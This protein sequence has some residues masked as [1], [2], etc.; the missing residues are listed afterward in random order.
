M[1]N[2]INLWCAFVLELIS[3]SFMC[4]CVC[5]FLKKKKKK[6]PT[7]LFSHLKIILLQCFQF[8]IFS[9]SKNKFNLKRPI[10]N[11]MIGLYLYGFHVVHCG[12]LEQV[13]IVIMFSFGF[14]YIKS[15]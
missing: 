6:G 8:S 1:G 4:V 14:V 11:L 15:Y 5:L 10:L 13:N 7:A 3:L 12:S 9:F 2:I